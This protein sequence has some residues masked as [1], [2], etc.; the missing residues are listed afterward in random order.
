MPTNFHDD[1]WLISIHKRPEKSENG[2]DVESRNTVKQARL[3]GRAEGCWPWATPL[4]LSSYMHLPESNF[5]NKSRID[6]DG[7]YENSRYWEIRE[8]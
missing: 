8:G 3:R 5:N 7:R 1:H 2:S 4:N 6:Q